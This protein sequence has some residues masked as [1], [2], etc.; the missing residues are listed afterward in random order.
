MIVLARKVV[1]PGSIGG[2][3][4]SCVDIKYPLGVGGILSGATA[5]GWCSSVVDMLFISVSNERSD[6]ALAAPAC[7]KGRLTFGPAWKIRPKL[8]KEASA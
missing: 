8:P 4:G 6:P 1:V 3:P 5:D 2:M 7:R